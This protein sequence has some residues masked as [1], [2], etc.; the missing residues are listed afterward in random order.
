MNKA[1]YR[2][3]KSESLKSLAAKGLLLGYP[4]SVSGQTHRKDGVEHH[5][6]V[7]F[8]EGEHANPDSAHDVASQLDLRDIDAEQTS[9]TPKI[10]PTRF[11]TEVHVLALHGPGVDHVAD[12]HE[13]L[14]EFGTPDRFKFA[15]HITVDKETYDKAVQNPGATASQLGIGFGKPALKMGPKIIQQYQSKG[16][17]KDALALPMFGP[18]S[19][20]KSEMQKM[21]GFGAKAALSIAALAGAFSPSTAA[22]PQV[23]RDAVETSQAS[24]NRRPALLDAIAHVESSGGK[25]TDHVPAGGMHRG[26]RAYGKYG[27]MPLTIKE[28]VSKNP[29]MRY[30]HGKMLQMDSPQVHEYMSK[31][32][33]LED[34]VAEAY[35]NRLNKVFRGKKEDIAMAWLNGVSGTMKAKRQGTDPRNHWY[36][37][38][39]L[40]AHKEARKPPESQQKRK[41]P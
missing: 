36:V 26:D 11:G 30:K 18:Q 1:L 29:E 9:V 7:K 23:Q 13:K 2:L 35:Y 5:V 22:A 14:S 24:A 20:G 10:F 17:K 19:F 41:L 33:G 31:K 3:A 16:L 37:Q 25:Y 27:L 38:R 8:F 39:V 21:G 40:T 34:K 4:A 28:I 12:A 15:P 6:T 32:P